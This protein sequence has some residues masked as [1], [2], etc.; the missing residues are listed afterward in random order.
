MT[1]N[2]SITEEAADFIFELFKNKLQS[3]YVYH[4]LTHTE[5]VVD[6]VKKISGKLNLNDEDLEIV[7]L[8]AWFH[9]AGFT[10]RCDNHE[11][12]SIEIAKKF[13]SERNYNSENLLLVCGCINAT[14]YPQYP[15][16]ILEEIICDADLFHLGGKNYNLKSDLL[17]VEW[18]KNSGRTYTDTEW[19]KI[20]IDFLTSHKYFTRYAKK[21]LDESKTEILVKLQKKYRKKIEEELDKKSKELKIEV[22]KQKLDSEKEANLKADRGIET[23]FRNVIRTHVEFSAMA[24]GK[25]N[26]MISVNTL[27]IGAL[28]TF[29]LRKLDTNPQLIIPTFMLMLVSLVCIIFG[30][31]VTRP[32][33]TSGLFTK[34]DIKN[35]RTNLLFFG[36]FFNM[37]LKDFQ[38][39][40]TEMM[41]DREFLY[42]SMVKD[43]YFLGQVLGRKYKYL[44]ICYTIFMYGLIISV[45]AYA[46]AF[47][48]MPIEPI[49]FFE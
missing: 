47:M 25:A 3:V 21:T 7:T 44:R 2:K 22:E 36:N 40:M 31:L 33:I 27:I 11:D 8:A 14:R 15:T 12:A 46:V 19:L 45:V 28:I 16:N 38:W 24:D 1:I 43:F 32:N 10:E 6:A 35:K 9:D 5:E 17:R 37:D 39:G 30:V 13:L 49:D 26:I 42:G 34:E 41:N 18:E 29:L 48:S 4:N 20:N 23:M